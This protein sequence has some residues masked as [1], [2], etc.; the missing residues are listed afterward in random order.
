M[1]DWLKDVLAPDAQD[2]IGSKI[3][4]HVDIPA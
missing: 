3:R 2:D 1:P 4:R